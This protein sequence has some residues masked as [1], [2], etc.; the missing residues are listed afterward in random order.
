[1]LC[2]K[3]QAAFGVLLLLVFSCTIVKDSDITSLAQLNNLSLTSFEI[4]QNVKA[5]TSTA[6]GTLLYD[7]VVNRIS[8]GTGAHVSRVKGFS[9]PALGNYK[10][11]LRSGTNASTEMTIGYRDNGLLNTFVIYQGDSAVEI[12]KFF[13]NTSNQLIQVVTDLNP[14]DN[15]PE[16]LHLKDSIIYPLAGSAYPSQIFRHS[17]IDVTLAGT[18]TVCQNCSTGSSSQ[19]IY[20][21][22]F[23]QSQSNQGQTYQLNFNSGGDGCNSG[24]Y[25]PYAC[26]GITK[27]NT[28][29]NGGS[30]TGQ[31]QLSFV[32]NFTFNTTIQTTFTS[33]S[34]SDTFYFHP[35]LILKD[36]I[37]NGDFYFWF[38][39]IDWFQASTNSFSNNDI[40]K[41]NFS[42]GQ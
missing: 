34:T 15:K 2:F 21:I 13:Y 26:G 42:Y 8:T 36:V 38:Y 30:N 16:M 18:Y 39:S 10:M 31:N 25:Y 4:D 22:G 1:M 24:D 40:I 33:A 14:V 20:Q 12:Y 41:I 27:I 19:A 28:T 29:G 11:K 37:L 32:N 9:F 6:V 3:K 5:G 23:Q 7:S 17:P 35:L